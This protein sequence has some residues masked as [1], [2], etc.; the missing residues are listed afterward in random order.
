MLFEVHALVKHAH[1][2]D[3]VSHQ[4]KEELCGCQ[5]QIC[6]SLDEDHRKGVRG[7]D[8]PL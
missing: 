3:V 7:E 1:D 2:V 4:A 5:R 6:G 8:R